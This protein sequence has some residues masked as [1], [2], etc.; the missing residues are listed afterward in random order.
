MSNAKATD[1]RS[2]KE[3]LAYKGISLWWFVEHSIY[4][5]LKDQSRKKYAL[6]RFASLAA[7]LIKAFFIFKITVRFLSGRILSNSKS[8]GKPKIIFCSSLWHWGEVW[9]LRLMHPAPGDVILGNVI[10][11]ISRRGFDAVCVDRDDG[12]RIN[13][14]RLFKKLSQSKG[15]WTTIESY[16]TAGSVLKALL[17]SA[18]IESAW[19]KFIDEDCK[20]ASQDER[21]SL[22][23]IY[24]GSKIFFSYHVLQALVY[25]DIAERMLAD[26]K[27]KAVIVAGEHSDS[28]RAIVAVGRRMGIPT[29]AI[30]HGFFTYEN[31]MYYN[32]P[33]EIS[34]DVALGYKPLAD[35]FAVYGPWA[36]DVLSKFNY[37]KERISVTGQ[38]RY[39]V[40]KHLCN[41][42]SKKTFCKKFGLE[43]KKRII[44]IT[45]QPFSMEKRAVFLRSILK[46]VKK[47]KN[48]SIVIKPHPVEKEGWHRAI[49]REEKI[50]VL[51]LPSNFN[52]YEALQACDVMIT[53]SS[54]TALEAM[55]LDKNVIIA[56]LVEDPWARI[57]AESEA[58]IAVKKA[59]DLADAVKKVLYNKQIERKLKK[60]RKEFIY[61]HAYKQ[62]G[63]ATEKVIKVIK[64]MIKERWHV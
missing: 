37:P 49:A 31:A 30:Q 17:Q 63:K 10:D 62:D 7:I 35:R 42:Y 13:L 12:H 11:E 44:L 24:K 34:D 23:K 6:N 28:G 36:A 8:S 14:G 54:T 18:R 26:E 45:T 48:V 39:D 3:V 29:M 60:G 16:A 56:N 47:T 59:E 15:G 51:V 64:Q 40:L 2:L 5:S 38:P 1:G 53:S 43:F 20:C 22:R 9:G 41:M 52:T 32:D 50:D 33:K 46:E 25:M 4:M 27:P 57:F 61:K 19:K 55:I 21:A 58:T